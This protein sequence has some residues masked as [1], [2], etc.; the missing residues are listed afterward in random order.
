M[1]TVE[2]ISVAVIALT[3]VFA[4]LRHLMMLQQSSYY[5]SRYM[6]WLKG[7]FGMRTVTALIAL[8]A[9]VLFTSLGWTIPLAV[10]AALCLIRL[11][12]SVLDRKKA[13]KKLVLTARVK[14]LLFTE[15]LIFA[16]A[17]TLGALFGKGFFIAAEV[18]SLA[19]PV[20][21]TAARII[22]TPFEKAV[23]AA[24]IADAKKVL[25]AHSGMKT[26]GITGSYGKTGT[27]SILLRILSERYNTVATPESYNTPLG[28]VRTV[29]EDLTP[30][31]EVFIAEMGAK[32]KGDID[33]I[34]RIC[35]P[36]IGII[37]SIGMQ[38]LETFGNIETVLSTKLELADSVKKRGGKL[39]FNADNDM[40]AEK[41]EE[42]GAVTYGTLKSAQVRAKNISYGP[43]GLT[44]DLV[45]GDLVLPLKTSLLGKHN[46]LNITA[47]AAVALD[48]GES[49]EDIAFAVSSLR[50][51]EHRLQMKP[52]INGS[53][54]LDDAYNSNPAGCL[55][56]INVLG[57]FKDM[58]KVIVTPG[59]V[60]LGAIEYETNKTVG[61]V[62]AEKCDI[63]IFVGKKRSE[64]LLEGVKDALT[65]SPERVLT[66]DRFSDAVTLLGEIC[67]ENT[68]VLFEND[69]PDNYAG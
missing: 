22:N 44:F 56:A 13:I 32:K 18:L 26:V 19:A 48:L 5:L 15:C 59:L 37:T 28:V 67:D 2:I 12:V 11:Y 65:G 43:W 42:Y 40:L 52:Y 6:K 39:Y 34:C 66:V 24:Y 36:D 14:R 4:S 55:E 64:P 50:P 69:L 3:G 58:K 20:T 57:S 41:A 35:N 49:P 29:R 27:K 62:A 47:A 23:A 7:A 1:K 51:V 17:V 8:A 16:C 31:T 68:V 45:R 21:V 53:T 60:E 61:K 10:L 38:H 30:P 25:A 54:L 9:A 46:A 33:E 63:L